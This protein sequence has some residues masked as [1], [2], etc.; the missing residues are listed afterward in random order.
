MQDLPSLTAKRRT[1]SGTKNMRRLR[2]QGEMPGVLYGHGKETINVQLA[3]R[4]VQKLL[5]TAS[6][7]VELD[8]EGEKQHVLFRALQRDHLGDELQH[9]D[10]VR[11]NLSDMVR[12]RVPMTFVGTPK[13]ASMGG[14]LET[15]HGEVEMKCPAD[16][17]PRMIEVDVSVLGVGDNI[18]FKDLPLPEGAELIQN[19]DAIVVKCTKARRA[20]ALA[21][22]AE[23]EKERKGEKPA[24]TKEAKPA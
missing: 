18:H 3:T 2:T 1:L 20:A 9:I 15:L 21:R 24:A 14:L 6:H 13:G 5:D 4:D 7:V 19:P 16:R 11:L 8:L 17:I 22:A 12:L 23:L 10:F